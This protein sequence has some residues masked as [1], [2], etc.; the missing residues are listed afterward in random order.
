MAESS[1]FRQQILTAY[2]ERLDTLMMLVEE[3][4][5]QRM[6][7]RLAG[8]LRA[9]AQNS[10]LSMTHQDVAVELGTAREVISRLL[11]D[12]E[13]QGWIRLARGRIEILL[14]GSTKTAL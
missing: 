13:R 2:G 7:E 6:D 12:F 8:W 5:F 11:K 3:I 14:N 4:A 10:P 1:R 9:N